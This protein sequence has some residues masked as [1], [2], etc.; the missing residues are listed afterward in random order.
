MIGRLNVVT[1]ELQRKLQTEQ[2]KNPHKKR[3]VLH[4]IL[5][6][7]ERMT[8]KLFSIGKV[9]FFGRWSRFYVFVTYSLL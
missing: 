4:L 1:N 6:V 2:R 8:I 3:I 5:L 9:L 7:Y